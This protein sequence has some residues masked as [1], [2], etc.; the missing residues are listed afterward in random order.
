MLQIE[1]RKSWLESQV[2]HWLFFYLWL[3][4]HTCLCTACSQATSTTNKFSAWAPKE[5]VEL[6]L[7]SFVPKHVSRDIMA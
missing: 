2:D 3:F 4:R 1:I 5:H 7:V 6:A